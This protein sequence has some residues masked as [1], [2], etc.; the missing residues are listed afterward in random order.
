MPPI[1]AF[2]GESGA[3]SEAAAVEL[4][5]GAHALLPCPSFTSTIAAVN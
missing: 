2:Q 3:F 4:I 1:V 5:G